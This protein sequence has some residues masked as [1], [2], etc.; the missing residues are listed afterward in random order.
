MDGAAV[1]RGLI[2]RGLAPHIAAGIAGNLEVESGFDPAINE[3]AP[4]VEGSRG[5]FGLA[6]WTGPRRRQYEQFA[7][8]R[9]A[10]LADTDT[11]LD[12]LLWELGNSER[13]AGERLSQAKTAEDAARIFSNDFLRPGIPHLDRR[14]KAAARF[15][16]EPVGPYDPGYAGATPFNPAPPSEQRQAGTNAL[17]QPQRQQQVTNQLDP[18]DFMTARRPINRLTFT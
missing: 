6:Q 5:G 10:D 2:Q 1:Y 13:R 3:I 4:L 7:Q 17:D 16:G 14:I 12:F 9:G 15:S 8:T 11:Q 18:R